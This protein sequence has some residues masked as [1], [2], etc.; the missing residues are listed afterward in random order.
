MLFGKKPFEG[1]PYQK[2]MFPGKI[3]DDCKEFIEKCLTINQEARPDVF[4]VA[5]LSFVSLKSG[6]K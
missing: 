5:K 3:S 6:K 1:N 2:L 4:S